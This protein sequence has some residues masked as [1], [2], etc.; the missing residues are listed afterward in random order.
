M[1]IMVKK[2]V[3]AGRHYVGTVSAHMIHKLQTEKKKRE[4]GMERRDKDW[5]GPVDCALDWA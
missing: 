4:R 2:I 3:V 1:I 5:R